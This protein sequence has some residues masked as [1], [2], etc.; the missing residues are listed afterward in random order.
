MQKHLSEDGY[1]FETT[2]EKEIV[3]EIKEKLCYFAL[4]YEKELAEF[5]TNE[6]KKKEFV[7]P[8]GKKIMVGDVMIRTPECLFKPEML[9]MDVAG[10][11]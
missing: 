1:S 2:A 11:H 6:A 10:I 9:G 7:L 3:K 4:D 8:D 5:Q